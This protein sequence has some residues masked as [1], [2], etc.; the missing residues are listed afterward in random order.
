MDSFCGPPSN[1]FTFW[2]YNKYG[3]CYEQL[4]L[5]ST[6]VIFAILSGYHAGQKWL[7]SPNLKRS[8]TVHLRFAVSL[9][10]ALV[11]LLH[12][13]F[14]VQLFHDKLYPVDYLSATCQI[15]GWLTHSLYLWNLREAHVSYVRGHIKVLL[16]W[17]MT[18][19]SAAIRLSTV[20]RQ[21]QHSPDNLSKVEESLAFTAASLHLLYILTLIP[22]QH[23]TRQNYETFSS[24]TTFPSIN[25]SDEREPLI[26]SSRRSSQQSYTVPSRD[27]V[28]Q[29]GVAGEKAS[30]FSKLIFWW[31][32]PLLRK[33]ALGQLVTTEDVFHLPESVT[34]RRVEEKFNKVILKH[35]QTVNGPIP[36]S[37]SLFTDDEQLHGLASASYRDFVE[38]DDSQYY[39]NV[40]TLTIKPRPKQLSLLQA[41]N[42]T[43]G[44]IY[45]SLGV[46]QFIISLL[47]FAGP[48]LLNKLVSFMESGDKEP[49]IHGYYYALGLFLSTLVVAFLATHYD[50][51]MNLI[52]LRMRAALITTIYRK[53]LAVNVTNMAKFSTGEIVNFMSVD[54]E[55][56]INFCR[57]FHQLWSLPV[58]IVV[59]LFLL[60][61]QL[62]L[63]FLAGLAFAVLLIPINKWLTI[64][65]QAY[66]QDLM[67]R[68]DS[69]VKV[70]IRLEML[71]RY[72]Y[73]IMI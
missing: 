72:G 5:F 3:S 11:P 7:T 53:S 66:N 6:H 46:V 49:M 50:Y 30:I 20:I 37:G 70:S 39:E 60:Q 40:E 51:Q 57:S 22:S 71:F 24:T 59:A 25:E 48:L 65:I 38:S 16:S 8:R 34:A 29:L 35:L 42:K 67:T 32:Q 31:I 63:A 4:I 19:V 2:T 52:I 45:F 28:I 69:R 1:N 18:F 9:A 68:K 58:Q 13:L 27:G 47:N 56:V 61:Q 23:Q 14:Q 55:R 73:L 44:L 33:G 12:M 54:S 21:L 64:K 10:G 36:P 26:G 41:L 17:F 43:F 62:G 15:I